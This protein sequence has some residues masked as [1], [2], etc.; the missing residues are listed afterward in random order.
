[1]CNFHDFLLDDN[2]PSKKKTAISERKRSRYLVTPNHKYLTRSSIKTASIKKTALDS[3][4]KGRAE[5]C[6]TKDAGLIYTSPNTMELK[7][8]PNN[9]ENLLAVKLSFD[10]LNYDHSNELHDCT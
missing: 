4:R 7:E 2:M 8:L 5:L 9:K 1:M 6:F 10:T 3:V